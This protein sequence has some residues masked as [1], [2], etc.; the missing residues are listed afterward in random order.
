MVPFAFRYVVLKLQVGPH[1]A[2]IARKEL[3]ILGVDAVFSGV[4]T[5]S[6]AHELFG[7]GIVSNPLKAGAGKDFHGFAWS[8]GGP[9]TN[10]A[11]AHP[12]KQ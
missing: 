10:L 4:R 7:S 5:T 8:I 6:G 3:N 11:V 2:I 12:L 1:S 9:F